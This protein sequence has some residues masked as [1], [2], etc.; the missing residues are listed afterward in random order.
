MVRV[1]I[2][3]DEPLVRA[4]IKLVLS[5]SPDIEVVAEA[6]DGRAAV[7]VVGKHSVDVLLLDIRMPGMDGLTAL[8]E[9]ARVAPSTR[10]VFLT[11]FGEGEY[12]TRALDGGAAGFLLKD[13][14]P[15]EL[16]RAVRVVAAGE[17]YLSP[18]V[19]TWVMKR[20]RSAAP[21]SAA[22]AHNRLASLTERETD[23]LRL[24]AQGL[25]N[26]DISSRLHASEATVKMYVS[27]VLTKL[28]CTNRV[29]AAI[30]AHEAGL[31]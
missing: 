22:S 30:M 29:Q 13:S 1:A 18:S 24:L 28:N 12:I 15:E 7:E 3:D 31:R 10:V 9:V 21:V 20:A 23:V 8:G 14:A 17:S 2:A 6:G 19:T 16:G 4:G 11:T 27:R 5:A 26:A 25:S